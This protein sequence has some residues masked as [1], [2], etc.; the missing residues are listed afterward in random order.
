MQNEKNQLHFKIEEFSEVLKEF[1]MNQ[2]QF[3]N[4]NH[5]LK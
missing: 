2:R 5:L 4:E 1:Q 3:E